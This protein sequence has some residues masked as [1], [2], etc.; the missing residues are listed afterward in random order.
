MRFTPLQTAFAE[1]L[2]QQY[3]KV[4]A[5]NAVSAVLIDEAG[6]HVESDAILRIFP[7]LDFPYNLGGSASL[8]LPG[9]VR[10]PAYRTFASNRGAVSKGIKKAIRGGED[11]Y[12]EEYRDRIFG[13]EEPL[14]PS[15]GF[16]QTSK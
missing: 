2:G 10:D 9:F 6:C 14:D 16:E 15:W 11:T 8:R 1:E 12:M 3:K 4:R 5:L 7:Y 13:L